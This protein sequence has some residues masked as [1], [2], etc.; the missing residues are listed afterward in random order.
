MCA[1]VIC[2]CCTTFFFFLYKNTVCHYIKGGA[3]SLHTV[4][5]KVVFTTGCPVF[6]HVAAIAADY[7]V[8]RR[9]TYKKVVSDLF[10]ETIGI[11]QGLVFVSGM[12]L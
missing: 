1:D 6:T 11:D 10:D 4:M 2:S 9:T 8:R 3:G 7:G 5:L 12:F